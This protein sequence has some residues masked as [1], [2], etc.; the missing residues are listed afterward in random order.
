[1]LLN[2]TCDA[3]IGTLPPRRF[4]VPTAGSNFFDLH[5]RFVPGLG[6]LVTQE[7]PFAILLVTVVPLGPDVIVRLPLLVVLLR[8]FLPIVVKEFLPVLVRV[9]RLTSAIKPAPE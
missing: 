2:H 7:R 1:M 9:G 5:F 4:R 6:D 3:P 8:P